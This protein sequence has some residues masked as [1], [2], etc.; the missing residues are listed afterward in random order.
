VLFDRAR[1]AAEQALD[2]A[3]DEFRTAVAEQLV[4]LLEVLSL[5]PAIP[6]SSSW[7]RTSAGVISRVA[8]LPAGP[9]AD[10]VGDLGEADGARA[11]EH[12]RLPV[13]LSAGE[14]RGGAFAGVAGVDELMPEVPIGLGIAPVA[15]TA[16]S[17]I[18]SISVCMNAFGRSTAYGW[19]LATRACSISQCCRQACGP[20]GL[21]PALV[22]DSLSYGLVSQMP[23][24]WPCRGC[25]PGRGRDR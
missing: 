24:R 4:H 9:G 6:R 2:D 21:I 14:H 18:W 25:R 23:E 1:R 7:R 3:G 8:D 11:G 15:L 17:M 16:G 12:Q 22:P 19:L 13:P 5:P 10:Q 20:S